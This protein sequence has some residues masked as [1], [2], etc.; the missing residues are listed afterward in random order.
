MRIS[1]T[2][3]PKWSPSVFRVFFSD[4]KIQAAE[5]FIAIAPEY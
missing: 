4:S 5:E 1:D 2:T 3:Q